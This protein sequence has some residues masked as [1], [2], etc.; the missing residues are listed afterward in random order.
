M[1]KQDLLPGQIRGKKEGTGEYQGFV[2]S[3]RKEE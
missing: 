1:G 3:N 2:L